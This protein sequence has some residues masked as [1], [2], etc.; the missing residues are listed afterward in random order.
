MAIGVVTSYSIGNAFT[1][2]VQEDAENNLS[3]LAESLLEETL[4]NWRKTFEDIAKVAAGDT[5]FKAALLANNPADLAKAADDVFSQGAATL[6]VID[7]QRTLVVDKTFAKILAVSQRGEAQYEL[8]PQAILDGLAARKGKETYVIQT[9]LWRAANGTPLATA[10]APIGIPVKA[11][12]LLHSTVTQKL[13]PIASKLKV[14]LKLTS[15][16]DGALLDQSAPSVPENVATVQAAFFFPT[17]EP[18]M[19]ITVI[20]NNASLAQNLSKALKDNVLIYAGIMLLTGILLGAL[21]YQFFLRMLLHA[22]HELTDI[23]AI[24]RIAQKEM[25]ST[26][27]SVAHNASASR[28]KTEQAST[29]AD[30][31]QY[32]LM[33][34]STGFDNIEEST[35][36]SISEVRSLQTE[37][38]KIMDAVHLIRDISRSTS[39]LALN[40]S[41]E[42]ARAG[43]AGRGF[44]VVAEEVGKLA[45]QTSQ[46][47]ATIAGIV[48]NL[49][50]QTES[51]AKSIDAVFHSVQ[52]GRKQLDNTSG[53]LS[54]IL[55]ETQDIKES[56]SAIAA[57]AEEQAAATLQ[58]ATQMERLD[59]I[60][61]KMMGSKSFTVKPSATSLASTL[62]IG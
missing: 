6:G 1:R 18:V 48:E 20:K 23:L 59:T 45:Q 35:Q 61:T 12:L 58:N 17:A 41:I 21:F 55:T 2:F 26:T 19:Q 28:H 62:K 60:V 50:Q 30:K 39:L 14:D 36:S 16:G 5:A 25:V 13:L 29:M 52:D 56:V 43:D 54:V 10:V 38:L 51:T 57:A 46:A 9:F 40:A 27:Q 7:L 33:E 32:A 42:A 24:Y 44:S 15:L 8:P 37:S 53:S 4:T 49:S 22:S 34:L 3:M 11:Y 47:T 31:S